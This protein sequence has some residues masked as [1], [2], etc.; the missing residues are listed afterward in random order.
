[1]KIL[2]HFPAIGVSNT[3]LIGPEDGG[4][5]V[6]VDPGRFDVTL[7]NLIE[8]NGFDI[9]AIL[10]TH[11]HG[12][13]VQGL[14]TLLKIYDAEIYAGTQTVLGFAANAVEDGDSFWAAGIGV[15]V[16]YVIGHTIDSRVYKAGPFLFTGDIISAGRCGATATVHA[17]EM[18]IEA[19]RKK[20][21]SHDDE[22]LIFPGHGPPTTVGAEKR[23]NPEISEG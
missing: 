5:A 18:M 8:D 19:I 23:W 1:M 7:L 11:D 20:I 15:E 4:D 2:S 12:N 21:L 3:Y 6:L 13:H 10:A 9:K 14:R 16:L 22:T 17:R